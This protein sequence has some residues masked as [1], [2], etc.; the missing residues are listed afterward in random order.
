MSGLLFLYKSLKLNLTKWNM[1][2]IKKENSDTEKTIPTMEEHEI[3]PP[4]YSFV[5]FTSPAK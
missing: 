3:D 5:V 2:P 1:E 4:P